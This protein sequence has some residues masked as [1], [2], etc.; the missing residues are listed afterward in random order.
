MKFKKTLLTLL[1]VSS[2]F[3]EC[4]IITSPAQNLN[5][6]AGAD[7]YA[8]SVSKFY[9][10]KN[11]KIQIKAYQDA[12]IEFFN[13]ILEN[14]QESC[15]KHHIRN[16]YNLQIESNVDKDYYYFNALFDFGYSTKK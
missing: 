15:K 6:V 7:A 8:M 4:K 12:Y 9:Y 16:I 2:L 13:K 10:D 3:G 11:G 14:I 1:V 5:L